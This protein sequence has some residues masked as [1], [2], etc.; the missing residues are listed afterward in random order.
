MGSGSLH[1][2]LI[3]LYGKLEFGQLI[4]SRPGQILLGVERLFIALH[5]DTNSAN[6]LTRPKIKT[7]PKDRLDSD[8]NGKFGPLL[9]KKQEPWYSVDVTINYELFI[10]KSKGECHEKSDKFNRSAKI[11]RKFV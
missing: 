2:T 3:A 4:D 7:S 9:I 1:P 5:T 11:Q 10:D 6:R 8:L